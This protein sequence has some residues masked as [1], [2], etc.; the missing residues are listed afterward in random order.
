MNTLLTTEQS[1]NFKRYKSGNVRWYLDANEYQHFQ[2]LLM[3]FSLNYDLFLKHP[4]QIATIK[5]VFKTKFTDIFTPKS[6]K[7]TEAEAIAIAWFFEQTENHFLSI[8]LKML[9]RL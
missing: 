5:Q 2:E 3:A 1:A 8:E 4:L 9:L 7:L 6:I